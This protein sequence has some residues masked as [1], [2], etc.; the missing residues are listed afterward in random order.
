MRQITSDMMDELIKNFP[1]QISEGLS[2]GRS[3]TLQPSTLDVQQVLVSGLG[4]SGIGG[5]LVHSLIGDQ[6]K[7]PFEVNKDY[8]LL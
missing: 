1:N 8:L 4:G 7:V 2:I 6:L 5:N 3:A